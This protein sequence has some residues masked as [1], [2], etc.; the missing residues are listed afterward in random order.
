MKVR[1]VQ[2]TDINRV[3]VDDAEIPAPA[4]D[5]VVVETH[6]SCISPGTELRSLMGKQAGSGPF[7]FVPGYQLAGVI[8][9][10]GS[11][12]S[13]SVG[14]RVFC[15]G[16][17]RIVHPG[18]CWG[19]HVS[20]AVINQSAAFVIPEE[21]DLVDASIAKLAAIAYHGLRISRPRPNE[22]VAVVGL[23]PLGQLSARLHAM[24][25]AHVVSADVSEE[26]VAFARGSGLEAIQVRGTLSETFA[27][28][29]Q[30]GADLVVDV[31]GVPQVL[32]QS[33]ELARS[34]PWDD[35]P[36]A[37]ARLLL[38]GSYPGE[39]ELDYRELF[40][41]EL[42]ILLTRDQQPRD[43]RD[44]LDLLARRTFEVRDII[45][46][47][48]PVATAPRTYAELR[49]AKAGLLTVAFDWTGA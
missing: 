7:P 43:I 11:D 37:G 10:A 17:A 12:A 24:A 42:T 4:S 5:E 34:K 14:T 26:R 3:T 16:S 44:V 36:E 25:G 27:E 46:D 6:F 45:S 21:V 30:Q 2:F 22:K 38:Q 9:E 31:T 19:G 32:R 41:R 33:T 18:R 20:H 29:F 15:S 23:G 13:L 35:S 28:V 48:R 1:A 40:G 49:A 47:V 8:V 39:F